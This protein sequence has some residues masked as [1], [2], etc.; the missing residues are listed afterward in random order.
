MILNIYEDIEIKVEILSKIYE[1]IETFSTEFEEN[2]TLFFTNLS[3]LNR[4]ILF[5]CENVKNSHKEIK[6]KTERSNRN[7]VIKLWSSIS[8][9]EI[10]LNKWLKSIHIEINEKNLILDKG[11]NLNERERKN[12]EQNVDQFGRI[13]LQNQKISLIDYLTSNSVSNQFNEEK[14]ENDDDEGTELHY[15][16]QNRN[17]RRGVLGRG[18]ENDENEDDDEF[19]DDEFDDE[20]EEEEEEEDLFIMGEL[21]S[22]KKKKRNSEKMNSKEKKRKYF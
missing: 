8:N 16:Y 1:K 15:Q 19:D 10:S 22:E 18:D 14:E 3:K 20:F 9:F 2:F 12:V 11:T 7:R 17:N 13:K 4:T 21:P 6:G 5:L